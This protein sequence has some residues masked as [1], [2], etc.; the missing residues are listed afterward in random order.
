L[1]YL[2]I[3]DLDGRVA[4]IRGISPILMRNV[5]PPMARNRSLSDPFTIAAM[6]LPKKVPTTR[7]RRLKEEAEA[8]RV[9]D[10]ID[11]QLK[12]EQ[13]Q[14]Y[15][16]KERR[17]LL[18][19][20]SESGKSTI[21]K[22]FQLVYAPNVF[23]D[24]LSTWR[25]V[26]YLNLVRSVRRIVN[27]VTTEFEL[28]RE[29]DDQPGSPRS[30]RS[31]ERREH[32]EALKYRLGP[33]MALEQT[34]VRLLN[35]EDMNTNDSASIASK[36]M[37]VRSNAPWRRLVAKLHGSTDRAPS[38]SGSAWN[39]YRG[40]DDPSHL[41]AASKVDIITLWRDPD[42]REILSTQQLRLED[43]S[44]FFLDDIDRIADLNYAPSE[45][46][47][48][49]ARLKTLGVVEKTF[50]GDTS[51]V[52]LDRGVSW[53]LYDVGGAR[54]QRHAW[55]PY[56]D[57]VNAIIFLAPISAFDQTLSEDPSVNRVE[58]SLLLWR[59]VCS[60]RLL[61]E[62]YIVLFLN[63]IDL[64]QAKLNAGVE[65]SKFMPSY[66]ERPNDYASISKYFGN[67]F[68]AMHKSFS[69]NK[70][71]R[72]YIHLTSAIDREGTRPIILNIRNILLEE[73]LERSLII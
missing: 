68:F 53:K 41:L 69:P 11:A 3:G 31:F 63:K 9:S 7:R 50:N 42:I 57:T 60:N 29:S 19:G 59:V 70:H 56:F 27:A 34:L 32:F 73:N 47:V 66:G 14:Q 39:N 5:Q 43:L 22:Q 71:R 44:G 36:E 62:A 46:D 45:D 10:A 25:G 38:T 48:L 37:Y 49:R 4:Q 24:E 61:R 35:G 17:I 58:D 15:Q 18:L 16:Q 12:E 65:L 8:K 30:S 67:K 23:R 20:Q 6:P 26:I 51:L 64:L 52:G 21:L 54:L 13:L 40:E 2:L 1:L 33:L 28:D 72:I 55:I